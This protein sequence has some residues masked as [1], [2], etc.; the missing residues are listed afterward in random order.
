MTAQ[1]SEA[2]RLWLWLTQS[3]KAVNKAIRESDAP[4]LGLLGEALTREMRDAIDRAIAANPT[5]SGYVAR[6]ESHPALFAVY[7]AWHVMHGMGQGGKFSLYPHVRKALGMC[8]ELGHGEREP[9]WRAF[10]RSLLNLGLE[11]SPRTSGPHFMADEYVRQA[12]VP[13]PFVDDLAERMLVFAKRVGL[14]DDD[15]PEGIAT[16]QAA[17]DVRLGPPFSQTARDAL[18]LDRLGYYTRTFLR[19]YANGGQN[20]EAGN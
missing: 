19:V 13:L 8:D 12:G 11:P 1:N 9:L 20:V 14:P 16:W 18:K 2:L 3:E 6:L 17:L 15:D 4:F 7:L 10:R 5:P